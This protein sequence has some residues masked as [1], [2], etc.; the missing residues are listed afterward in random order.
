MAGSIIG[1]LS[2]EETSGFSTKGRSRVF[3]ASSV[4][5][6]GMLTNELARR[7]VGRKSL[8][9]FTRRP[10]P[11]KMSQRMQQDPTWA[12]SYKKQKGST[13]RYR[14]GKTNPNTLRRQ[15]A[16]SKKIHNF[17]RTY[18]YGIETTDGINP[19]RHGD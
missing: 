13:F 16:A 3:I 10:P 17:A 14:G 5:F 12:T 6:Q 7:V 18:A 1:R 9:P 19:S 11:P 2:R 4:T 15:L 8:S